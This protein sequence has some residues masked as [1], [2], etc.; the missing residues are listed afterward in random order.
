MAKFSMCSPW[1]S[2]N[3]L[4]L[5]HRRVVVEASEPTLYRALKDWG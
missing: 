3:A 5:D 4:M 1:T 2:I